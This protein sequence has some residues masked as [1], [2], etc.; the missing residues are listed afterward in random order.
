M[1]VSRKALLNAA[2][3]LATTRY[4]LPL[5][6]RVFVPHPFAHATLRRAFAAARHRRETSYRSGDG[7]LGNP[8]ESGSLSESSNASS[9]RS[10]PGISFVLPLWE[11]TSGACFG[12]S[13]PFWASAEAL[14]A[15]AAAE[16]AAPF[17][18]RALEPCTP[19]L[20][21]LA[22]PQTK[23]LAAALG[24]QEL[25]K[26]SDHAELNIW[27]PD[28]RQLMGA[29]LAPLA[30]MDARIE[31][32]V[33]RRGRTNQSGD[34]S[35]GS[36]GEGTAVGGRGSSHRGR[37][38]TPASEGGWV[39]GSLSKHPSPEAHA[40]APLVAWDAWSPVASGKSR[41]GG[42]GMRLLSLRHVEEH[43]MGCLDAATAWAAT[44]LGFADLRPAP[45]V[46]SQGRSQGLDGG[47]A[48]A[49]A[50]F[51]VAVPSPRSSDGAAAPAAAATAPGWDVGC[52]SDVGGALGVWAAYKT[53]VR[54][55][56]AVHAALDAAA[57]EN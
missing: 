24:A 47:V 14:A 55:A 18:G 28:R 2:T 21:P 19:A 51:G 39:T 52:A 13:G 16:L 23:G 17:A 37:P 5:P 20:E 32:S 33:R 27:P 34:G 3:D 57:N 41:R 36:A 15:A 31:A 53:H 35:N 54:R 42:S 30:D 1:Q 43:P 8:V 56:A 48:V 49:G 25:H 50:A 29:G 4:V 12:G 26:E 11:S 46:S 22:V 40:A 44:E 6:P 7:S 9:S 45:N 10:L 38:L